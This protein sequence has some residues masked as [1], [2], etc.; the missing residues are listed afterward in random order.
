MHVPC[1]ATDKITVNGEP[2]GWMYRDLNDTTS[3]WTFMSGTESQAYMDDPDNTA[4]Y[5]LNT[6]ANYDTDIIPFLGAPRGAAFERRTPSA[7][8]TP[9][10]DWVTPAD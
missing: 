9:V 2:V 6:I 10:E 3:G 4:I 7:G 1:Y 5:D 8:F